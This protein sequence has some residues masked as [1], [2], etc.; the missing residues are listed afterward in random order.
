MDA[1]AVTREPRDDALLA[2]LAEWL[3]GRRWFPAKGV[4]AELS[5]VG[6]LT[7]V[8]PLDEAD[9]RIVLVR[10]VAPGVDTVLQ[11]PLT[12]HESGGARAGAAIGALGPDELSAAGSA[13][14]D[15]RTDVADG[16]GDP[17]FLR[18]WL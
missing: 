14:A 11:V 15:A 12:L 9:V 13:T 18:A 8:D 4:A 3:P 10:T 17:A 16:A 1:R 5:C 2:L 6:G 7:L